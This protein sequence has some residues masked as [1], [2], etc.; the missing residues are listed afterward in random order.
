MKEKER[1][2]CVG[3]LV[4]FDILIQFKHGVLLEQGC[5]VLF[6]CAT[7]LCE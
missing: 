6:F 5:L 1:L 4:S 7:L 2:S 3:L